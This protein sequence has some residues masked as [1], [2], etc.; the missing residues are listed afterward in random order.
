MADSPKLAKTGKPKQTASQARTRL[1]VRRGAVKRHATLKQ[2]T[3]DLAVDV[4]WDRREADRRAAADKVEAERR[5]ADRRKKPP[6]TWEVADFAVVVE[7]DPPKGEG[8]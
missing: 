7:P 5:S 4:L 1:I 8:T 2:K 3:A 6:F